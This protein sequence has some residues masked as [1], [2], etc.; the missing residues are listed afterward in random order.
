M[1]SSAHT[2]RGGGGGVG[3]QLMVLIP[4]IVIPL[5]AP[6]CINMQVILKYMFIKAQSHQIPKKILVYFLPLKNVNK[7]SATVL[8]S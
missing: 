4:M 3:E 1:S 6:G 8:S 7:I 5:Y 2:E